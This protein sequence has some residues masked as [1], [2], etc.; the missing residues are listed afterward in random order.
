VLYYVFTT[1]KGKQMQNANMLQTKY[2]DSGVKYKANGKTLRIEGE[3][4]SGELWLGKKF[5]GD[6]ERGGLA[7]AATVTLE[8]GRVF[9]VESEADYERMALQVLA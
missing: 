9:V 5:M 6:Y 3:Y 1:Q 2:T 4:D 8:D 7:G